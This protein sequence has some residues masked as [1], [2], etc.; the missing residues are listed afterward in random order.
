MPSLFR[1]TPAAVRTVVRLLAAPNAAAPLPVALPARRSE[2]VLASVVHRGLQISA[3][4]SVVLL[5]GLLAFDTHTAWLGAVKL[6]FGTTMLGEGVLLAT[7]WRDARRL[8][9]SRLW[10]QRAWARS[11]TLTRLTW[12]LA[13]PALQLLGVVWLAAGLLTALLGLQA[14]F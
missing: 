5:L 8:A 14:F 3:L 10:S 4:I 13:S 7:N 1:L 6:A 12:K 2:R 11:P 9:L